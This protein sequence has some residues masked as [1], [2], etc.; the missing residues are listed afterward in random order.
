MNWYKLK[1]AFPILE[2]R[3]PFATYE[4]F[5][6]EGDD[7]NYI[8]ND[9]SL[10][11]IDTSFNFHITK[12]TPEQPTHS[13]WNEFNDLVHEKQVIY[14]GRYDES[15]QEASM[16]KVPWFYVNPTFKQIFYN[17]EDKLREKA[18]RILD[19][20]FNNPTIMVF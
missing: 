17:R 6:H 9:I 12:P 10:W 4:D 11:W 3:N 14:Q 2:K 8:E 15:K 1:F 19:R 5:R 16:T 18:E 13:S 20:K 7:P